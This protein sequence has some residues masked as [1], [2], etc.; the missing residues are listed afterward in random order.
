[1]KLKETMKYPWKLMNGY[2]QE[3]WLKIIEQGLMVVE[4][5]ALEETIVVSLPV[6]FP[7]DDSCLQDLRDAEKER[8]G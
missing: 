4:Q 2:D 6:A 3:I 1:M 7:S 5:V 8:E